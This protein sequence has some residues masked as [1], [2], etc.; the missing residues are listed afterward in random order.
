MSMTGD[1]KLGATIVLRALEEPIRHIAS[2][3]GHDGAVVAEEVKTLGGTMGF[4]AS[5]GE[6][7]DMFKAG[8][9]DP[10]KVTRSALQ[11]AARISRK[12]RRRGR[13]GSR[14]RCADLSDDGASSPSN[15]MPREEDSRGLHG[16]RRL[17]V[18]R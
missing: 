18:P 3:G 16:D 13:R 1:E 15:S 5:T 6:Y 8:I 2:N 10:T 14:V 11:N 9:V 4:N 12:M 17:G 7:V